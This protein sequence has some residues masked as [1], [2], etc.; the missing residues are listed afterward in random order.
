MSHV[1]SISQIR[2]KY[3][4]LRWTEVIFFALAAAAI[5]GA[6]SVILKLPAIAAATIAAASAT[7]IAVWRYR[8]LSLSNVDN[9]RISLYLNRFYPALKESSDLLLKNDDSLSTLERLQINRIDREIARLMPEIKLPHSLPQSFIALAVGAAILSGAIMLAPHLA[10]NTA[11]TPDQSGD[12]N[13]TAAPL[14]PNMK[15]AS[16]TITPPAYTRLAKSTTDHLN[17]TAVEGSQVTWSVSFHQ[18]VSN[19]RIVLTTGDSLVQNASTQQVEF[20]Y[21]LTTSVLYRILWTANG[22]SHSS[23]YHRVDVKPDQVPQVSIKELPQFTRIKWGEKNSVDVTSGVQDDYGLTVAHVIATVSKGSGESVKFREEKIP[24]ASPTT[25]GGTNIT[26]KLTLDFKK[27]GM[28]PGDEVYFYVEAFDNKQP[29]AQRNRTDTYFIALQDTSTQEIVMDEG[30]GVDLMPDYFRSQR[31]LIIDTEKLLAEQKKITKQQFNS[32]SNELG[33]DQKVL[34]LRYGQFLGEE[35]ETSIGE[36]AAE[37]EVEEDKDHDEKD[38]DILKKYGH[39]HDTENEHNLVEDKKEKDPLEA[40]KHNHDNEESATF[41]T[42]SIK[43]KLRA[44]L[45]LMWDSE[46]QLRLYQ[47]KAS[48]PYQYQILKLLKEIA[49]D[50]RIYVHRMGFD[51]PPLKEEKRLTGSLEEVNPARTEN[52]STNDLKYPAIR[53]ALTD[54]S[55]ALMSS[56]VTLTD[57]QRSNLHAAGDE[58]AGLA[59]KSPGNYLDQLSDLKLVAENKAPG[60]EVREMLEEIQQALWTVLPNEAPSPTRRGS[61]SHP[62]DVKFL[63][64]IKAKAND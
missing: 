43:V 3:L 15:S 36:S 35:F 11:S 49:Q 50:S 58:L 23:D 20:K 48:L 6:I 17:F 7:V 59:L 1:A 25:I 56:P 21:T 54:I 9:L 42:Q 39:Q 16:I 38:E 64:E 2:T 44:A 26:G 52:T 32:T 29:T 30:L 41:F 12:S 14:D 53:L 5:A 10:S 19:A 40:Y 8:S 47:P 55:T 27:L 51:P 18:P 62:L 4:R 37:E 46:L 61:G 28:D 24:F 13:T 31:Q 33:Y 22:E 34:R 63:E 57:Q 60:S 45:T